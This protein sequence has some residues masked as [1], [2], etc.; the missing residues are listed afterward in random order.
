MIVGTYLSCGI[1]AKNYWAGHIWRILSLFFKKRQKIHHFFEASH[2]KLPS[3]LIMDLEFV[4]PITAFVP[5][6]ITAG[7]LCGGTGW[8]TIFCIVS[9][10]HDWVNSTSFRI[11]KIAYGWKQ[12]H[13]FKSPHSRPH[14]PWMGLTFGSARLWGNSAE[15]C[16]LLA[17][18]SQ[19]EPDP[20]PSP[21]QPNFLHWL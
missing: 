14:R 18:S 8:V 15:T 10:C 2:F 16:T 4:A 21:F 6:Y 12:N 1:S 3:P 19:R 13:R 5:F 9:E 20:P 11:G 17:A 7:P